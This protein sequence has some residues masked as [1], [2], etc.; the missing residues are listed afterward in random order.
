MW[1]WLCLAGVGLGFTLGVLTV[2]ML[3][4]GGCR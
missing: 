3:A 1:R 2:A 4:P